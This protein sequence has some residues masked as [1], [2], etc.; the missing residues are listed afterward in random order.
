LRGKFVEIL[1]AG[2]WRR[3]HSGASSQNTDN[4]R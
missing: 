1:E 3:I 2:F 4:L